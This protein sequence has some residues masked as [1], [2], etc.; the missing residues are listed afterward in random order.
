MVKKYNY[1]KFFFCL[2]AINLTV[3]PLDL[4]SQKR[5]G[6]T[7]VFESE[8]KPGK[9]KTASYFVPSKFNKNQLIMVKLIRFYKNGKKKSMTNSPNGK[10]NGAELNWYPN[11][12][13]KSWDLFK[14]EKWLGHKF[15]YP[16]GKIRGECFIDTISE[17]EKHFSYDQKGRCTSFFTIKN[18]LKTGGRNF[19]ISDNGNSWGYNI[20]GFGV[21]SLFYPNGK[22]NGIQYRNGKSTEDS[23]KWFNKK[24][25]LTHIYRHSKDNY[26]NF[27]IEKYE[28]GKM[29]LIEYNKNFVCFKAE[30]FVN[31]EWQT[32]YYDQDGFMYQR[33]TSKGEEYFKKKEK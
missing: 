11:G 22:L 13:L 30:K 27:S 25:N 16:N 12:Q 15:W 7:I 6:D 21:D 3:A 28:H 17:E 1:N 31:Q 26:A 9:I 5:I 29:I 24:G 18:D 10:K 4:F 8:Y 32:E 33:S 2:I 23:S 14:N 19:S 20:D